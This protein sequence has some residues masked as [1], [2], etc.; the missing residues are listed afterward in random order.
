VYAIYISDVDS[1]TFIKCF[2]IAAA[3]ITDFTTKPKLFIKFTEYVN[4]FD[5]EK[6]G[7]LAAY[8]KNEYTINLNENKPSFESLYNLSAKKLEV[9]KT[10]LNDA[11][12]KGWIRRFISPARAL[13]LFF[14]KKDRNLRLYINYRGLNKITIKDRCS[15]SFINETLNRLVNAAYYTKLNLKDVYYRIRIKADDE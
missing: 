7:V 6:A 12:A 10:Y 3:R 4:V 14:S 5:I 15:F 2:I 13:V 8:N 11:L 9:L 1:F